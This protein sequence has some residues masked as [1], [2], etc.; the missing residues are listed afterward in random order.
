MFCGLGRFRDSARDSDPDSVQLF[1]TTNWTCFDAWGCTWHSGSKSL[2][3]TW[4]NISIN[5]PRLFLGD[6]GSFP[7]VLTTPSIPRDNYKS[8]FCRQLEHDA[9]VQ[10]D[11]G[12]AALVD[13]AASWSCSAQ[14]SVFLQNIA[15]TG[16]GYACLGLWWCYYKVIWSLQLWGCF[17]VSRRSWC[18]ERWFG[19]QPFR[20]WHSFFYRSTE[21]LLYARFHPTSLSY[22]TEWGSH[23]LSNMAR[24]MPATGRPWSDLPRRWY[25][26]I[27]WPNRFCCAEE[28]FDLLDSK[29]RSAVPHTSVPKLLS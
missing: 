2:T 16:S 15:E 21:F 7:D 29:M 3:S 10:D 8:W 18:P 28:T 20:L 6:R 22:R 26:S 1:V 19:W 27:A 25:C 5:I 23:V 9:H 12:E 13:S 17:V 24:V 4:F 11:G 14:P